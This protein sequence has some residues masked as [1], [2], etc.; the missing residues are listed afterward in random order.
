[1]GRGDPKL[2][3][4]I[5]AEALGEE[6]AAAGDI[7]VGGA[8]KVFTRMLERTRDPDTGFLLERSQFALANVLSCRPPDNHLTGAPYE[9][10]AINHCRP[11]LEGLLER[12]K[13]K[14]I[15]TLGNQPLRW[16]T[17]EWGI[18]KLR[19]YIF[20][21]KWGPVIPTYH[22]SYI[23]RGNFHLARVWQNDLKRALYV[24]RC[25]VPV[26]EKHY[27]LRP[28]PMEVEKWV[29]EYLE[30]L[31]KDPTIT[32]AFDIE[33]PHSSMFKDDLI[34][35]EVEEINLE[36]DPSYTI[37]R[38][39]FSY[40]SG[41]AITFPWCPPFSDYARLAL[42]SSGEKAVWNQHF[43]CPR[44]EANGCEINGP[45]IDGMDAWH[46][47]EPALPMG[48]KYAATFDCPDMPAWKL[49]SKSEPEWYSAAD[50]DVLWRVL[51]RTKKVLEEQGRWGVFDKHFIQLTQVLK[52]MTRRGIQ[53][54]QEKRVEARGRFEARYQEKL[55]ELAPL[56]PLKARKLKVYKLSE[57]TL[58]KRGLDV[59][60]MV[61][62]KVMEK[63]KHKHCFTCGDYE[64]GLVACVCAHTKARPKSFK[65]E[66]HPKVKKERKRND[67]KVPSML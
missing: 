56:I 23:M 42:A 38:I 52:A 22:P 47:R 15:L 67:P 46:F 44:L 41:E 61:K 31:K 26:L 36:D 27:I 10:G 65:C 5:V 20:Q 55:A 17:G 25:G 32:L 57:E 34:D 8:G 11:H 64:K 51:A 37:N 53:V 39:S 18:E 49:S 24:A 29:Q 9:L 13:P 6:E 7:L 28:S 1:V 40:C 60:T 21:S 45:L 33:T 43:D 12:W 3:V 63:V 62:V 2:G 16:F 66:C 30:T 19:G 50:S 59:N 4:V 14:V 54:S 48:L 35:P 58:I